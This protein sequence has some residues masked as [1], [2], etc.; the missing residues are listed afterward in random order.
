MAR[1]FYRTA[2]SALK[3]GLIGLLNRIVP[4]GSGYGVILLYHSVGSDAPQSVSPRR[5]TRQM[6]WVRDRFDVRTLREGLDV[7][8][9][10]S[11]RPLAITF[12]DGYRNNHEE[13]FPVLESLGLPATFF[14][15]TDR[16]GGSLETWSGSLPMMERSHLRELV[17]AGHE[18]ASHGGSHRTLTAL[19]DRELQDEVAGSR[20]RLERWLS[21]PVTSFSYPH[22]RYDER[23]LRAVRQAGYDR[24]VTTRENLVRPAETNPFELPR[25]IIHRSLNLAAFRGKTT[26]AFDLFR[27]LL[28]RA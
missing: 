22:G 24:A 17:E 2:R 9:N 4:S 25:R 14:V 13:A 27:R 1:S 18:V 15:S 19:S 8:G 21:Q 28:G 20:R 26:P 11:R 6:A 5:F 16:V 3:N 7:R 23:V 10:E 12:D